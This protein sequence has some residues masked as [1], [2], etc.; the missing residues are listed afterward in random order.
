WQVRFAITSQCSGMQPNGSSRLRELP[1][2]LQI[3]S[4]PLEFFSIQ[5]KVEL[6]ILN[7]PIYGLLTS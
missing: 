5:K 7:S 6:R 2:Y 3:E 4:P 1:H